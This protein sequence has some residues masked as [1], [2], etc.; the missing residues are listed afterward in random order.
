[1]PDQIHPIVKMSEVSGVIE[2]LAECIQTQRD[3]IA[4]E[5]P[6]FSKKKSQRQGTLIE[7][8][9]GR[10]RKHKRSL[11]DLNPNLQ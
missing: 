5:L 8:S 6:E 1:M 4:I 9:V 3:E 10:E 2:S 11:H 7:R